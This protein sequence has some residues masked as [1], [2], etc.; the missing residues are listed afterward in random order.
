[1][2]VRR[3]LQW[4]LVVVAI[5]CQ[6]TASTKPIL[7]KPAELVTDHAGV[8]SDLEIETLTN[9]LQRLEQDG[10]AQA[11]IYIDSSLPRGEVMEE[12][13]LRSANAWGVGRKGVDDGLVIFVFMSDRR[14]R[15]E[16]GSGLSKAISD[17]DAKSIIDE[18][19]TPAFR[20][21]KFADGL[22]AAIHR[23]RELLRRSQ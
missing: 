12:L 15:I 16:L 6:A 4:F 2:W 20:Q 3:S 8:L 17:A 10:L 18:Q 13:T 9:E 23:V 11:I 14:M 21:R 5:S 22:T 19:L 7:P 1:M